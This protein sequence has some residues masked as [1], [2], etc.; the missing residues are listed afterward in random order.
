MVLKK[1][2]MSCFRDIRTAAALSFSLLLMFACILAPSQ[3]CLGSPQ[4]DV[5]S[6]ADV[7]DAAQINALIRDLQNPKFGVREAA[8]QRLIKIGSP[9]VA[10]LRL[11]SESDSLE[12]RVRAQSILAG[13]LQEQ[14]G[15][16][17]NREQLIIKQ[18]KSADAATRVAILK[19]QATSDNT[20]LMLHLLEIV[21]AEEANSV[22][23]DAQEESPIET[24]IA[25]ETVSPFTHLI[26]TASSN[27]NWN[28]I[29][30]VLNHP[31][32]RKY[33]PILRVTEAQQEGRLEAYI[34]DRFKEFSQ[35]HE[36]QRAVSSRELISLIGLFRIQRDF[37]RA[38]TVIEWLPDVDLQKQIRNELLFQ[39]GDWAEILRRTKLDAGDSE[40]IV[41]NSLQEAFLYH[42]LGDKEG[43]G[44]VKQ[45]LRRQFEEAIASDDAADED[46]DP[47]KSLRTQLR[48]VGAVTLD[49]PLVAEFFDPDKLADN[50]D[51]LITLNRTD[52]AFEFLEIGPD[53]KSR[54]AWME[55][56]LKELSEAQ[57]KLNKTSGGNKAQDL[58][59]LTKLVEDKTQLVNAV[60][61]IME[62]R[63]MDDESQL[64]L[65]MIYTADKTTRRTGQTEILQQ[66]MRLGRT[67]DYWQLVASI[68]NSPNQQRF[69]SR[70]WF[71]IN[72]SIGG[73]SSV[74]SLANEWASR[75]QGA[76]IDP[77][78]QAKTI[79]AIVNSPFVKRDELDFDLDFEIARF[80]TR[81][82]MTASGSD[83]FILAQ[84]LELN[85]RDEAAAQMLE[86]AT[87]LGN[88]GAV[89]RSYQEA[90]AAKDARGI[91]KHWIGAY[92]NSSETCLVVER[93]ALKLLETETDPEQIRFIKQQL[94]ICR[95]AIA[96]KWI[97]SSV[98]DRGGYLPLRDID[99]PQLAIF[100][101]QCM[102]YGVPGDFLSKEQQ[103]SQL[104]DALS[105]EKANQS[106]Q[107]G[108]ELATVMF[109]ELGYAAEALTDSGWSY[110][111][112]RLNLALAQGKIERGQYDQ[113]VDLLERYTE[114]SPG[115][116]SVGEKTVKKFEQA[117]ETEAAD[118][119]YKAVEKYFVEEL[120]RYPESPITRNNYAWLSATSGRNLEAA[121]RHALVAL[122]VRPNVEHYL[123]TL[124]E[125][126]FLLGRPKEAYKLSKQCIRL[127][128]GRSYY[129]RQTERFRKA[130]AGAE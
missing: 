121:K 114:F 90:L 100:R 27:R 126:E 56:T 130:M 26:S 97:G 12:V 109:N 2:S 74:R 76:I 22:D 44:N 3:I 23:D 72:D 10:A 125:V 92:T 25:S 88:Y 31:G 60:T 113:A 124:A 112:M 87:K 57:E 73:D 102:V 106:F 99:E 29:E 28:D 101:L 95:L 108:I 4:T 15:S 111:S 5:V 9:A 24:L 19:E 104:G 116:T 36:A 93:A 119:V 48:V 122:Q 30:T 42:L 107:G 52:E 32:I 43:V 7:A 39:Q 58:N 45:D 67:D 55:S 63:G 6:D 8:S 65:Q 41:T 16:F 110:S 85:E 1:N 128:P 75:I 17:G 91:L 51:L 38:E 47:G 14:D 62:Q 54:Q 70:N 50:F 84:I 66:L 96:A 89:R 117:G 59:L 123:D 103:H 33:S 11:A 71:G 82:R 83:E 13:I 129:R 81:S 35:A 34:E 68:I 40:Y 79:A 80:R 46:A 105:S 127:N 94:K 78:E 20:A 118:R 115:D 98:W 120:E 69:L 37:K 77:L 86:Q 64:Y 61:G 18:F 49:W 21:T 53:F